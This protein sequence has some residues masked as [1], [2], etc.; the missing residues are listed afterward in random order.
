MRASFFGSEASTAGT[1]GQLQASLK[2]YQHEDLDIRDTGRIEALFGRLGSAVKVV[3]HTAA[4]PSHDWAARYPQTDFR[5][6][7]LA[8][9]ENGRNP[10]AWGFSTVSYAD[11]SRSATDKLGDIFGSLRSSEN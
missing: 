11:R 8:R 1:K 5:V 7:A 6:N 9:A 10:R 3:I 2:N 4:Q